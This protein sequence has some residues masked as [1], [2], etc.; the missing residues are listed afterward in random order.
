LLAA[1]LS[2]VL[3]AGLGLAAAHRYAARSSP[4]SVARAYF[5]ALSD[6]DA[7][8]ALALADAPPRGEFL[9]SVVLRRQLQVARLADLSVLPGTRA[10]ATATVVVRYRLLFG[11]GARSVSDTVRLVRRGSVWRMSRVAG[12]VSVSPGS[13][14]AGRVR[15]AGRRLPAGAVTLFPG[16]LPL[17]ADPAGLQVLARGSVG[18]G[19]DQPI[20]RL[21]D[22]R[23]AVK[24]EVSLSPA[25][26]TQV[27]QATQKLLSGCLA[28]AS[29]DPL[30]PVPNSGRAV[31]G[32]L[33]G[34]APAIAGAGPRIELEQAASGVIDVRVGVQVDGKWQAWDFENQVVARDGTATVVLD[35]QVF[36]DRP[37]RAFWN[38]SE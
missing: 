15:L 32:S 17:A 22:P 5:Q 14:V 25:L 19:G 30:C 10:G 23:L 34:S 6:G 1:L 7:P 28:P 16:A 36:L 9:T 24:V 35:A 33:H 2:A 18:G 21:A 4:E 27:E 29:H 20:I 8:A 37:T 31:P 12:T 3:A 11:A 38:P 26:R 13:P